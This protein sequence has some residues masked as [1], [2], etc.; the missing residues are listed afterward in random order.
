[1]EQCKILEISRASY[2]ENMKNWEEK[3][4]KKEEESKIRVEHAKK[5][6]DEWVSHETYGYQKMSKHLKTRCNFEWANE[7]YIRNLYFELG[8]KG[9]KPVF[10]TTKQGKAPYGKFPYL[11]RNKFIRF[12][13]QVMA[14]DITYIK[15]SWGMMYFTAVID[16]YSRKILSWRLSDNMKVDFCLECVE[17]A[18]ETYGVP[19]IFNSDCGSQYTSAAFIEL[20]KSYEIQ[21]SMDGIG[22]CKDNIFV[23]RTWRTLKYEWIFLRDYRSEDE[24]RKS[25]GE[26][27]EFFNKERIHQGL[28]YKTPDE[29][30]EAGLIL[31]RFPESDINVA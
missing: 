5:V 19:A 30:Y 16:L 20:L 29:V 10:K 7:K 13:N 2:Y 27:V 1:L 21:I 23:E 28:D 14:T 12:S 18:F 24:L 4:K 9:M 25:L 26:F 31:D 6:F 17:E 22:R 8:I 3:Q 11:L 15:T